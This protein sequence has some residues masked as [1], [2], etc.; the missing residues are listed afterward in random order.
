MEVA[1]FIFEKLGTLFF[2]AIL[3]IEVGYYFAVP[4]LRDVRDLKKKKEED[5]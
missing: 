2:M 4:M 1:D 5:P 3:A